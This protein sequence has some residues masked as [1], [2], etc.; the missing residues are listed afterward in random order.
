MRCRQ[1]VRESGSPSAKGR[2]VPIHEAHIPLLDGVPSKRCGSGQRRIGDFTIP[3]QCKSALLHCSPKLAD[4]SDN[5]RLAS[6]SG[7]RTAAHRRASCCGL[8]RAEL[9]RRLKEVYPVLSASFWNCL[10]GP[11]A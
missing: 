11:S 9:W 10:V 7:A 3:A 2:F 1:N 8:P 5:R 4:N 6:L